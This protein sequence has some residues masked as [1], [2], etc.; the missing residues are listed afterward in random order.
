M[1][2]ILNVSLI[3]GIFIPGLVF[4]DYK[5]IEGEPSTYAEGR[6]LTFKLMLVEVIL[7]V[8]CFGLNI[9]FQD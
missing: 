5:P 7:G 8:I 2:L 3:I 1:T 9:V 6:D 4:G